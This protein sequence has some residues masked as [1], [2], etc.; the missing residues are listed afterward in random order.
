MA[1][2]ADLPTGRQARTI[3]MFFTYVLSSLNREYI[4]VGLTNDMSRR[5][6]QHNDGRERTTAPY[7]PF[8]LIHWESF[9]TRSE[10]R[11]REKY[12]KTGSGKE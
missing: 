6:K 3:I 9:E 10:A 2:L 5:V 1:K 11:E 4:Y 7:R 12:F 8:K